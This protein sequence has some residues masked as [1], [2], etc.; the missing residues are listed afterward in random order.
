M[1]FFGAGFL[2]AGFLAVVDAFAAGFDAGFATPFDASSAFSMARP[3][4][5][6]LGPRAL[7]YSS[8]KLENM[9]FVAAICLPVA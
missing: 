7:S 1:F 9:P 3:P 2:A 4:F 6:G 5:A 8:L